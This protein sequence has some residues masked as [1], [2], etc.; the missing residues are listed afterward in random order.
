MPD[1]REA[2]SYASSE[3]R[4]HVASAKAHAAYAPPSK[5]RAPPRH[6][7]R[8]P[9]APAPR[10]AGRSSWPP[11]RQSS[12]RGASSPARRAVSPG[13]SIVHARR[14][15]CRSR[16]VGRRTLPATG[17]RRNTSTA[18]HASLSAGRPPLRAS[19][20]M[21]AA[22]TQR[23]QP[24]REMAPRSAA[25]G[26]PCAG[27]RA[28]CRSGSRRGRAR[29]VY[30][31][32]GGPRGRH[33]GMR[34]RDRIAGAPGSSMRAIRH[35][36]RFAWRA[37]GAPPTTRSEQRVATAAVATRAAAA[38]GGRLS[39][40]A[41]SRVSEHD[42]RAGIVSRA[43]CLILRVLPRRPTPQEEARGDGRLALRR[44]ATEGGC[45]SAQRDWRSGRRTRRGGTWTR[46]GM[47]GLRS[48]SYLTTVGS[49]IVAVGRNFA[50][51]ARELGNE[52]PARP[53]F[54]IKPRSAMPP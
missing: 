2:A 10:S 53:F 14:R 35:R 50:A 13:G 34:A 30:A 6:M 49:K 23:T 36:R 45:R 16:A 5:R 11:R 20:A 38:G 25:G 48:P 43:S 29:R 28:L 40:R 26:T 17:R 33:G 18:S 37:M 7:R 44:G 15:C 54:F 1:A 3:H 19:I 52:V 46:S 42:L 21:A 27:A 24:T 9:A 41:A 39:G 8:P 32:A 31:D 47:A 12:A 51:H 4:Q 22:P